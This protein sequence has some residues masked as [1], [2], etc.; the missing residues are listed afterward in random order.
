MAHVALLQQRD[1][2]VPQPCAGEVANV[3]GSDAL[4]GDPDGIVVHA[5]AVAVLV[6]DRAEDARGVVDERAVVKDADAPRLEV[7]AP[8]ERV[9]ELADGGALERDGHRVDREVAAVKIVVDRPGCDGGQNSGRVVRLTARRDDVNALV[10]TVEDNG[11]PEHAV[12]PDAAVELLCKL[13]RETDRVPFDDNV[14]VEVRLV[15]QDVA[16][17]AADE[18]DAVVRVADGRDGVQH[19]REALG[20]L[21]HRHARGHCAASNH[22][23]SLVRPLT[24]DWPSLQECDR[25]DLDER[26]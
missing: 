17:R 4:T 16:D 26:A 8:A 23:L 21:E 15:E 9:D 7:D 14:D 25:F 5:E 11:C 10:V 19:R 22:G 18:V 6:A 1:Q 2:F 3:A 13:V 20:K 24:R 12:R